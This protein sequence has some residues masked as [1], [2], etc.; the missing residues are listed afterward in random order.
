M[1]LDKT[2]L[3]DAIL[4]IFEDMATRTEDPEQARIDVATRLSDA[5]DVYVKTGTVAT[6]GTATAQT[7]TIT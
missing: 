3:K 6:T 4:A 5:I 1:A 2:G 7:G